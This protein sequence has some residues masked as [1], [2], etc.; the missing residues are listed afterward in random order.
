MKIDKYPT[1]LKRME[2]INKR[3]KHVICLAISSVNIKFHTCLL[4][5]EHFTSFTLYLVL[6]FPTL[7]N[8]FKEICLCH[9]TF[10]TF[11][12]VEPTMCILVLHIWHT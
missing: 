1:S 10:A 11:K 6:L 12:I 3:Q 7:F 5:Y 9:E 4:Q 2:I 8:A